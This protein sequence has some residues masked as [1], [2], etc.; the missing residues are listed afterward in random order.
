VHELT[1]YQEPMSLIQAGCIADEYVKLNRLSMYQRSISA[2]T[3]RRQRADI[4]LFRDYLCK[5]GVITGNMFEDIYTWQG[6][7]FGL[8][9]GFKEWQ[10]QQGYAIGSINVRLATVKRYAEVAHASGVIDRQ[11]AALIKT[12]K[13]FCGKEKRNSDE[14]REVAR[15]SKKKATPSH[16][17]TAHMRALRDL[18]ER[19]ATY[20]GRRDLLL[21]C[22]LGYQGFRCGEI[23]ELRVDEVHLASGLIILYRRK[24]DKTQRHEMHPATLQAMRHYLEIAKPSVYLF[25]GVDH[26]GWV[27]KNGTM[28]KA[29]RAVDGLSTRTIN[30]RVRYLGSLVGIAALS[31]HDLRH[32]WTFD[33]FEHDTPIEVVQEAGGWSTLAMPVHYRGHAKISNKGVRQSK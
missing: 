28:H 31:P 22:L 2:E 1:P 4:E 25:E 16:V 9:E 19:D 7:S 29:S 27:D 18:L 14:K 8:I 26:K 17:S 30:E 23:A 3:L 11:T 20:L 6:I 21:L 12:V 32:H 13:G 10:Y 15:I 24:V 33:L 5:A